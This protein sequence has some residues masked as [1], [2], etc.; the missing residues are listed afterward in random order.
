MRQLLRAWGIE[1]I[2]AISSTP[3]G[4]GKTWFVRTA[5]AAEYVLKVSDP[6]RVGQERD[7][8]LA[9]SK[10]RVPVAAPLT[11]IAGDPG[12]RHHDGAFYCLYPRLPG[13]IITEHFFGD[14]EARA[15]RF[16]RALGLL[17]TCFQECEDAIAV[18]PQPELI[19]RVTDGIIPQ[20]RRDAA[21]ADADAIEGIWRDTEP[22]I[23]P[24]YGDLVQ[25]II[26]RDAHTSNMLFTG[27]RLTG[28]LDFEMVRRGLR[29]FDVCYC[30]G[31]ML[32]GGVGDVAKE[33]AWPGLFR[34]LVRGYEEYCPLTAAERRAT[35]AVF[36]MIELLFIAFFMELGYAEATAT[37][38]RALHWMTAHHDALLV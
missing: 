2:E 18:P 22:E 11:T 23:A 8:L 29:V 12:A 16:G 32:V 3:S 20:I 30:A 31:S 36:V 21:P 14:A 35:Y 7:T 1:G 15:R 4:S 17:H 10:T 5:S 13:E 28:W 33:R 26:H 25:H 38:I 37:S 24:L 19:D 34:A 6:A 9:L 27:D